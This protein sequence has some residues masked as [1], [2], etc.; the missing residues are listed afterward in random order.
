MN[1]RLSN[2]IESLKENIPYNGRLLLVQSPQC[3]FDGFN[4]DI[5]VNRG[6]YAYPPIGLQWLAKALID[7][8]IDVEILDLNY[9]LLE[10]VISD[11]TFDYTNWIELLDEKLASFCPSVVGV[12][13]INVN[14]NIYEKNYPLTKILRFLRDKE[15]YIIL[16]GGAIATDERSEFLKR[17]YCHFIVSHEAEN[18]INFL[19]DFIQNGDSSAT[20]L[21]KIYYKQENQIIETEGS[22]DI[23]S[24]E[25]NLIGTFDMVPSGTYNKIGSLNPYSRMVGPDVPFATFQLFRGCPAK[26]AYCDVNAFMGSGVRHFPAKV[27]LEEM[28]YLVE[29]KNIRH[30]DVV[31]DAFISKRSV[32]AELL[33]GVTKLRKKYGITWSSNNG[34]IGASITPK[35]LEMMSESGCVG[36]RIGAESGSPGM[37]KKMRKPATVSSLRKTAGFLNRYP[38][39]FTGANY[40]IGLFGEETI[41]QMLE[42]F[43]FSNEM[44]LDWSSWATFQITSSSTLGS[45][46]LTEKERK[47]GGDFVPTK[48]D[49]K[50]IIKYDSDVVVGPDVFSLPLE[51]IP[52][53]DQVKEVWFAFNFIG[54]FVNNKNLK[55]EGGNFNPEKFKSW[56]YAVRICYPENAYMSLF[57]AIAYALSGHQEMASQEY[58][59]TK[60]N[61]EKSPYWQERFSQYYLMDI[62]SEAPL[63]VEKADELLSNLRQKFIQW[64]L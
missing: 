5:A 63:N 23:V 12:T 54:N 41:G 25:G 6:Y 46:N 24:L 52:S 58:E 39:M 4:R 36:F 44:N 13:S 10:K 18:K 33:E 47:G 2:Y 22:D 38:K 28:T 21:K 8:Q 48:G 49:S 45:G 61:L 51:E 9:C 17:S 14:S 50:R 26:C 60:E 43:K 30:F 62:V 29:E 37:L 57:L 32:T 31:D 16:A 64:I 3:L 1:K 35:L 20:P 56:V 27:V 15:K 59:L 40:I 19:F 34:L 42:T 11:E 53:M 7:R 55:K